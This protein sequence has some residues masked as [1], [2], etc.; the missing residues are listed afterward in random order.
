[1]SLKSGKKYLFKSLPNFSLC[2]YVTPGGTRLFLLKLPRFTH[3]GSSISMNCF[4]VHR[5]EYLS[6]DNF[7]EVYFVRQVSSSHALMGDCSDF[8]FCNRTEL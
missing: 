6:L 7:D 4:E 2:V 5:E 8:F 1:M 3:Y